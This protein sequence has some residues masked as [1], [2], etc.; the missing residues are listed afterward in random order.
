MKDF[1]QKIV[2]PACIYFAVITV[3]FALL[4]YAIYGGS[5]SGGTLS[6]I[7]TALFFVFSLVFATANALAKAERP[8]FG[9]RILI[10]AMLTGLGFWLFMLMPAQLEGSGTLT[11]ILVYYVIYAVV[12]AVILVRRAQRKKLENKQSEYREL[13]KKD[14]K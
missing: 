5:V 2:V 13:F 14:R 9:L 1:I 10:H 11:G 6:A 8:S 4:V 12:L 3:P 7:R